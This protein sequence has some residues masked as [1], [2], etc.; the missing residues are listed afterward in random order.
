MLG[1]E[2]VAAAQGVDLLRP[3]ASS[4]R[5]EDLHALVRSAVP[6]WTEDREMA[7][8]LAAGEALLGAPIEPFLARLG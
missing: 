5:L 3:L 4:P 2:L 8:A 7:P 1:I 6:K